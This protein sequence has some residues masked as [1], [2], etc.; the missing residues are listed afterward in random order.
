M[1]ELATKLI[2]AC[3]LLIGIMAGI[4]FYGEH[5]Y[6]EGQQER[7]D[8]YE[9]ALTKQKGEAA[10]LLA[11]ET[12][13]VLEAER[14]LREFTSQQE[15]K[16]VANKKVVNDLSDRVR[17]LAGESGRLRDPNATG[18]G[19]SGAGAPG[20]EPASAPSGE[21]DGAKTDGLLS[22]PLTAL[23]RGALRDAD[24]QA[25]AYASCREYALKLGEPPN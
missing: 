13:K 20:A 8:Y 18:C 9:A 24:L 25:T 3:A 19:K 21:G 1:N 11:A 10:Q 12:T 16:D 17:R 7:T 14:K 2:A 6:H 4:Y 15:K 23:L 22:V 5:K